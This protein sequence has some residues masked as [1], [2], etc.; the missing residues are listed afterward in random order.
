MPKINGASTLNNIL[1]MQVAHSTPTRRLNTKNRLISSGKQNDRVG[2]L[3]LRQDEK[4]VLSSVLLAIRAFEPGDDDQE[5]RAFGFYLR[6]HLA[7]TLGSGDANELSFIE[8]CAEVIERMQMD[9]TLDAEMR[10]AGRQL[11]NLAKMT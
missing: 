6:A 4:E 9:V 2:S 8:L 7:K 3:D 10:T 11:L 1:Q 5:R